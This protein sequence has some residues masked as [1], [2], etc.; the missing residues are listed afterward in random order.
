V[1]KWAME[2]DCP[3][4]ESNGGVCSS[5]ARGGHLEV[6][7]W[8]REHGCPWSEQ[9]AILAAELGHTDVLRWLQD[10]D[11]PGAAALEVMPE[12]VWGWDDPAADPETDSESGS[13]SESDP[14]DL[15]TAN[16]SD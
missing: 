6:L 2:H 8:A 1:L 16:H 4:D 12:V 5:A 14:A 9:T 13:E 7:R 15:D 10:N 11:C 3:L